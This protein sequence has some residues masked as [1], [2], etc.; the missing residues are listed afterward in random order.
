VVVEGVA[1]QGGEDLPSPAR[2]VRGRWVHNNGHKG[3]DVVKSDGLRVVGYDVVGVE[4]SGKMGLGSRR[5]CFQDNCRLPEEK[6]LSSCHLGGESDTHS[7]L[8]GSLHGRLYGSDGGD[9]C[10]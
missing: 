9:Q 6:T 3:P 2:V 4:S 8:A 1:S 10:R 7:A 5:G